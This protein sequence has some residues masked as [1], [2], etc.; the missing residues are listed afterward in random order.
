[1]VPDVPRI[2]DRHDRV[3]HG[4]VPHIFIDKKGLDHGSRI[5]QAGRLND[6]VVEPFAPRDQISD[7]ADQITSDGAADAPVIHFDNF[8][9]SVDHELPVDTD[10]TKFI[11][12]Y[13]DSFIVL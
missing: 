4:L 7:D 3:Q 1:V 13:S 2:H 10:L 6:Q 9:L 12:D 11:H 5:C 8:L